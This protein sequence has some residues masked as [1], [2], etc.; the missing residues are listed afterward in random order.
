MLELLCFL[1]LIIYGV[2]KDEITSKRVDKEIKNGHY[3]CFW[4]KPVEEIR[5]INP[6]YHMTEEELQEWDR[7]QDL[8]FQEKYNKK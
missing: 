8:K 7:I 5:K 6:I 4:E 2:I 3:E 1:G